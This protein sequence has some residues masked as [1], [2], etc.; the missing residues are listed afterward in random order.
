ML[1]GRACTGKGHHAMVAPL[2]VGSAADRLWGGTYQRVVTA[3]KLLQAD[4]RTEEILNTEGEP[5]N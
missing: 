4:Q 2:G 5:A 1:G 3:P